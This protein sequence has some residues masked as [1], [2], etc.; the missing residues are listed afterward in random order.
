MSIVHVIE[1]LALLNPNRCVLC[2]ICLIII[3]NALLS[4]MQP[5]TKFAVDFVPK[6]IQQRPNR[7][8]YCSLEYQE[9]FNK[10][11]GW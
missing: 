7:Q 10:L 2:T 9:E 11:S 5:S 3:D 1:S 4:D 6:T 8:Y